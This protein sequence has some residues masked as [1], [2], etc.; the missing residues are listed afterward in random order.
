MFMAY[1][2][3]YQRKTDRLMKKPFQEEYIEQGGAGQTLLSRN[4][5]L[6]LKAL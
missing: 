3:S 2:S 6:Y 4:L 1:S 5:F